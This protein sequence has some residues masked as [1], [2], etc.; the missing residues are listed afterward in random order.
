M[1]YPLRLLL[2][3]LLLTV[4]LLIRLWLATEVLV[5]LLQCSRAAVTSRYAR[6]CCCCSWSSFSD[7]PRPR[8]HLTPRGPNQVE[9][10]LLLL[11]LLRPL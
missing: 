3:V 8:S 9:L 5:V 10:L 2:T 6:Y 1:V 7:R 11:L 4:L